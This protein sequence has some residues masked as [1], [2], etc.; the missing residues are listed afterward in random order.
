MIDYFFLQPIS[1][2]LIIL[3]VAMGRAWTKE[4]STKLGVMSSNLQ[5]AE[6]VTADTEGSY[7]Y[8]RSASG[9]KN[10]LAELESDGAV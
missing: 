7:I 2:Q 5:F 3:R 1:P 9:S 4:T 6:R 10:T 8:G